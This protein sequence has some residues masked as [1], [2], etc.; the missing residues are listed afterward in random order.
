[1]RKAENAA[2]HLRACKADA[3]REDPRHGSNPMCLERHRAGR[4]GEKLGYKCVTGRGFAPEY[5]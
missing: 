2:H 3:V 4:I 5:L 1:M